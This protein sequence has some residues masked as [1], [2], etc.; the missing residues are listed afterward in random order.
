M[1]D[2][3]SS[4]VLRLA[5]ATVAALALLI[6]PIQGASSSR[7]HAHGAHHVQPTL[8]SHGDHAHADPAEV[9][10]DIEQDHEDDEAADHGHVT[11]GAHW[12]ENSA[13]MDHGESWW[14]G[15]PPPR[16]RAV[17]RSFERPPRLRV[18]LA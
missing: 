9:A 7:D 5:V 6:A 12:H 2:W 8:A 11:P 18:P 3:M 15:A 17:A 1:L 14:T 4:T 13:S 16:I 10:G